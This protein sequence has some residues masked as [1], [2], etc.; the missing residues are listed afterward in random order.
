[1]SPLISVIIPSYNRSKFLLRAIDSILIQ[2]YKNFELIVVDDG[3]TDG[4]FELIE[5]LIKLNQIKYIRIENSGVAKARNV[6]AKNANG[7]FLAFLDS[8]DEWLPHKLQEQVDFFA[9][10]PHLKIVYGEELWIRNGKRVNQKFIHKKS[11]GWIF[12]ECVQQCLIAPSS[13]MLEKDLFFEMA[14]FDESFVVC[15]D[16]DLW[17]KISSL[18][19]IGF[20]ANPIIIKHGGHDDQLSTKYFAMDLWRMK[21]MFSILKNRNLNADHKLVVVDSL[22][23]RGAILMQGYQKHGNLKDYQLVLEMIQNVDKV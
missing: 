17:L 8:D 2:S 22:K 9:T 23:R 4:T 20:I 6:G 18:L 11:G 15:E 19:E 14:G 5:S 10:S 16:Y 1:M 7:K 21:S 13:V 3:S 12:C